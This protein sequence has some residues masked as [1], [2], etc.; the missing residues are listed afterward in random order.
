VT[1]HRQAL[2]VQLSDVA[3]KGVREFAQ[4]YGISLSALFE[5]IGMIMASE[6]A[7]DLPLT[8]LTDDIVTKARTVDAERRVRARPRLDV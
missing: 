1:E 5:A 4:Y 8:T 6:L 7:G 3:Q 2:H